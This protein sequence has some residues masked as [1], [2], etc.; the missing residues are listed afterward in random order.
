ML[1]IEASSVVNFVFTL[2]YL[3]GSIE[4]IMLQ[5]PSLMKARVASNHLM[6]L[7]GELEQANFKNRLPNGNVLPLAQLTVADLEFAYGDGSFRIGP[8]NLTIEK[9]EIVFIYGGNGSGKTTLVH[10]ILGLCAPTAGEIRLNGIPV[11]EENYPEYKSIFSVVFNNFYLFD[12]ITWEDDFDLP[13]WNFYVRL[14]ELEGKVTIEDKRFSTT[15][16]STGQRKRLALIAALMERKP[17]LV[18][19]EW[20]ADQDPYFRMKFYTEILPLLQR[21]GTT[22]LAITHDDK[23]Y[24][25][26]SRLFKMDE[27]HLIEENPDAYRPHA[28]PYGADALY[29]PLPGADHGLAAAYASTPQL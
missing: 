22:I 6:A 13:R 20:A 24:C 1:Q 17:V 27:G 21:E 3:L 8:V 9:G 15:D 14:F 2:L 4:T 19:D 12:E 7:K 28:V 25:C 5:F 11:T 16:L 10:S 29:A 23:Y 18:L 26:A